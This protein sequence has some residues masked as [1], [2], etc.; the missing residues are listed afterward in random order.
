MIVHRWLAEWSSWG[1][2]FFANHLWQ[3]TLISLVAF[4]AAALMRKGTGG[5]R[6]VVWLIASAKFVVPSALLVPVAHALGI[7]FSSLLRPAEGTNVGPAVI[8]QLSAPIGQF[9]QSADSASSAARGHA[10]LFCVLTVIWLAG[11]VTLLALWLSKRRRFRLA[12]LVAGS[13]ASDREKQ[14]LDRVRSW[15]GIKRQIDL[16]LLPG[17]VEPGVWGV[18]RPRVFLPQSIANELTDA[19]LEAVMMHEMVHVARWDNLIANLH[20]FLCCVLWFHP[21]VWLLDR[22]L[23]AERERACDEEVIRLGGAPEIYASSLLKVLRFCLGWSVVGVSNATGSNLGRRIDRIMTIPGQVNISAW[24][25]IAVGSIAVLV[26]TL[27]IA[28]GLLTRQ[29]VEAQTKNQQEIPGVPGAVPGGV[30]RGVP[31]GV[32]NGAVG[33]PGGIPGGVPGGFLLEGQEKLMERLDAAPEV[34][35][36]FKNS[37]KSPILIT[38][39]RLR[40]VKST[41]GD[42]DEIAAVP[43]LTLVNKTDRRV[44]GFILEFRKGYEGRTYFERP[45]SMIEP[46]GTYA[47]GGQKRFILLFGNPETWL[48][49]VGGV[50]FEDGEVWGSVPPP[51]PPP[52]P[53]PA[54]YLELQNAPESSVPVNNPGGAP[55]SLTSAILKAVR[56]ERPGANSDSESRYL[57]A[58]TARLVNNTARRITAVAIEYGARESKESLRVFTSI[59]LEPHGSYDLESTAPHPSNPGAFIEARVI[60]VR[61]E[62]GEIWG[63]FPPPPPLA[64][65]SPAVTAADATESK[66]IRKS[67]GVLAAS[68]TY[69]VVPES[70]PLAQ[71][72]RISGSVVVEVTIDEAGGVI[73]ARAISGHPLL[74]DVSVEAARQW[75]FQPTLL[76]GVP[77][78]VI[79]NL[80]FNFEP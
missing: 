73:A 18:W 34:A 21:L 60:G 16:S 39:A 51:P 32:A 30:G 33:V 36:E 46:G 23:L 17:T 27:S 52:P 67:G 58:L 19:E 71:A 5:T 79:G 50:I 35:V 15:L 22:L 56:I 66:L 42:G 10:E 65:P 28:A 37:T 25:R 14:A 44:R 40:A 13:A 47:T 62:D 64:A 6:Y 55:I 38:E 76:S 59:K 70:P 68:A 1:W 31:G 69:R 63:D 75:K 80:T 7:D 77:V 24:R 48:V 8:V 4:A 57:M 54:E 45:A 29:G 12:L 53:R 26:I 49:R 78:R 9:T 43:V 2:P 11:C 3:A 20:R 72:A 41:R 74:K 61:F